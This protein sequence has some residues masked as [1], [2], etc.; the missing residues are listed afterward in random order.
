MRKRSAKQN[1]MVDMIYVKPTWDK[2]DFYE[3]SGPAME[4]D[5]EVRYGRHRILTIYFEV[6]DCD[7][8][9]DLDP[10]DIPDVA[11]EA[12]Q[13]VICFGDTQ[14]YG[15]FQTDFRDAVEGIMGGKH[16]FIDVDKDDFNNFFLPWVEE[17][18]RS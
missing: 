17:F 5:M 1:E 7:K 11:Q 16:Y 8:F 18:E 15:G 3:G 6:A 14:S 2:H 13:S 12:I 10:F 4:Y 9:E